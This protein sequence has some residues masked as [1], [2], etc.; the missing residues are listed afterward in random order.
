MNSE[1]DL[2][3]LP[4]IIDLDS[5]K[6]LKKANTANKALAELKGITK[7]IPNSGILINTLVLQEAKD[8]SAIENIITTTSFLTFESRISKLE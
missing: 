6:I 7:T 2:K 3:P 4:P 1:F 8:S 5:V